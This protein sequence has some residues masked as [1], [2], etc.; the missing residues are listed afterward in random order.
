MSAMLSSP[1]NIAIS[2]LLLCVL[3]PLAMA[4]QEIATLTLAEGLL[5][6][7]RGAT[8][9]RGGE[10][11]RLHA[12]DI[13]ESSSSGFGQLEF[14]GGTVMALGSSTRFLLLS[15]SRSGPAGRPAGKIRTAEVVLLSGW[16]K[17]ETASNTGTY[18]YATPVLA[19]TTSDGTLVLHA[20]RDVS[21]IF[22]ESG[23][24]GICDVT[25][26]GTLGHQTAGKTGQFFTRGAGKTT[27]TTARPT[28]NFIDSMPP[29]FRDTLPP[30][31][32][33]LTSR[34]IEPKRDH[35]VSYSEI[36]PWLT[37]APA[38]RKGFVQRFQPRLKDAE[39]RKAVEAHLR[40]HPEWGP[41][42][43]PE[44][45]PT[46]ARDDADSSNARQPK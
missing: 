40:D 9:F 39:F 28:S 35:E 20:T 8:V 29:P 45:A 11:V 21:E 18:R 34:P 41:V 10:G 15:H 23:S 22:V 14:A 12:G 2:V 37:M 38:W 26:D 24:A 27:A 17:G 36:Q 5:Q 32:A 7:I 16:L 44:D 3:Q 43:H 33:H 30:R 25:P 31:L 4:A 42:L 1:T 46:T 6:V 19:A 13:I